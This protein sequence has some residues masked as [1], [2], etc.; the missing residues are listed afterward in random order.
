MVSKIGFGSSIT[1]AVKDLSANFSSK[2]RS[3]KLKATS[4]KAPPKA[5]SFVD[6]RYSAKVAAKPK[7]TPK[8]LPKVM[9]YT[10]SP[11]S[12]RVAASSRTS[13]PKITP[14]LLPKVMPYTNSPSGYNNLMQPNSIWPSPVRTSFIGPTLP[15]QYP[16][17]SNPL[18]ANVFPQLPVQQP[19]RD[20]LVSEPTGRV[21]YTVEPGDTLTDIAE[22][23]GRTEEEIRAANPEIQFNNIPYMYE[24][25]LQPGQT[26]N[27]YNDERAPII[28][29]IVNTD[30]SLEQAALMHGQIETIVEAQGGDDIATP[31]DYLGDALEEIGGLSDDDAFHI[32]LD[33]QAQIVLEDW[34]REGLGH[35]IWDPLEKAYET[36]QTLSVQGAPGGG[37]IDFVSNVIEDQIDMI[38]S[39][40]PMTIEEVRAYE[41]NLVRFAPDDDFGT[42]AENGVNNYLIVMP[43][44]VTEGIREV[45][46]DEDNGGII[47]ASEELY[48]ATNPETTTPLRAALITQAA[49]DSE[50]I[51]DILTDY[52]DNMINLSLFSPLGVDTRNDFVFYDMS[53]VAD[54]AYRSPEG[55]DIA[56]NMA[57]IL[58]TNIDQTANSLFHHMDW[59]NSS[60]HVIL[61]LAIADNLIERGNPGDVE[62]SATIVNNVNDGIASFEQRVMKKGDEHLELSWPVIE[63]I[64]AWDSS[65][66]SPPEWDAWIKEIRNSDVDGI[67][68]EIFD[69]IENQITEMDPLAYRLLRATAV[70]ADYTENLTL[71]AN[72]DEITI[73]SDRLEEQINRLTDQAILDF[74]GNTG[75][76]MAMSVSPSVRE[77]INRL[78]LSEIGI[79]DQG[80]A[81]IP[82]LDG[83]IIPDPTWQ[84]RSDRNIV[85]AWNEFA[86]KSEKFSGSN[87]PTF[88]PGRSIWGTGT[89]ALGTILQTSELINKSQDGGFPDAFFNENGW[90][91]FISAGMYLA[92]TGIEGTGLWLQIRNPGV[93]PKTN[94]IFNKVN[95]QHLAL[96][97][98]YNIVGTAGYYLQGDKFRAGALGTAT[99]GSVTNSLVV[100]ALANRGKFS[101]LLPKIKLGANGFIVAGTAALTIYDYVEIAQ[102]AAATEPYH[103]LYLNLAGEDQEFADLISNNSREGVN[104][105]FVLEALAEYNGVEPQEM[106]AWMR[107]TT[108]D[109]PEFMDRF[110]PLYLH[111]APRD[112][113]NNFVGDNPDTGITVGD[114][115]SAAWS[116]LIGP[117]RGGDWTNTNPLEINSLEQVVEYAENQGHPMP[118]ANP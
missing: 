29:T 63:P 11:S 3:A 68:S 62:L 53:S 90:R 76:S 117:E 70:A 44:E 55:Q 98:V 15:T 14:K 9:P 46:E 105:G 32:N 16:L 56:G 81:D 35:A 93:D 92:G 21:E 77:E 61:S 37:N 36:Q 94:A 103:D 57:D 60:G 51:D 24:S 115:L 80:L 59:A 25:V 41:A 42:L 19:D 111:P 100:P 17:G 102:R 66:E 69:V 52:N 58:V 109:D 28:E 43:Q 72:G 83:T 82:S 79:E 110:I 30:D 6:S 2:I 12:S 75:L 84:L 54:S 64:L 96:F 89:H 67:D 101:K 65:L 86:N 106:L 23:F 34:A 74:G 33:S 22:E 27:I 4:Y 49:E 112:G 104:T 10:N 107:E 88:G 1:N 108:Q 47:A 50:L 45:Y 91:N 95:S 116:N 38:D 114:V 118:E 13:T 99:I 78:A 48:N 20:T 5:R 87:R 71:D 40:M 7:V 97:A 18:F 113:D 8:P 85:N 31:D 73:S 26:L 39:S